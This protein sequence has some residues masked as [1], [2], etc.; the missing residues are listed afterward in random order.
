M[1]DTAP[2]RTITGR[3]RARLAG[4]APT[5][6]VVSGAAQ[7]GRQLS[8]DGA[9]R[10][11]GRAEGNDL[12]LDDPTVSRHHAVFRRAGSA[13]VVE[14]A[15][16]TA[17]VFVDGQRIAGHA[18]LHDGAVI[19][20]G[21][22]A[23]ELHVDGSHRS[24]RLAPPP[25]PGT[26]TSGTRYDIGWQRGER[27]TN[28]G[29]HQY[30]EYALRFSPLRRR[31]RAMIRV[32][33]AIVFGG[34]ALMLVGFVRYLSVFG[35]WMDLIFSSSEVAPEQAGEVFRRFV[36]NAFPYFMGGTAVVVLGIACIVTGLLMRRHAKEA[37]R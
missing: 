13:I 21:R 11:A 37:A 5:L 24:G 6:T 12:V 35:E 30:N 26:A 36:S 27:I 10:T 7:Q 18:L 33:A 28:I 34:F 2:T 22:V 29:G 4:T 15:G 14:D 32:G 23:L 20:L 3:L 17:G 1:S 31:A 16:S 9:E 19:T 8:L 25:P